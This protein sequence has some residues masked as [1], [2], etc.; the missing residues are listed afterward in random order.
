[1]V[2]LATYIPSSESANLIAQFL[3]ATVINNAFDGVYLDGYERNY[4]RFINFLGNV[5][6]IDVDGDGVPDTVAEGALLWLCL[7][8]AP[9]LGG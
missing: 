8:L 2:G 7:E 6:Q 4:S 1:M 5:S 3:N 9:G